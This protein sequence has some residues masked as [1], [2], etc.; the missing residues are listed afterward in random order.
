[1]LTIA[2]LTHHGMG[3]ATDGQTLVPRTLPGEVVE[4]GADGKVRII[5]PSPDRVSAPCLHYKSCGGC[6]VQHASDAFVVNWKQDIVRAA[7]RAQGL[8]ADFRPVATSPDASRRR[9]KLAGQR[10][11]KGVIVGFYARASDTIVPITDCRLLSPG[12]SQCMPALQ[13]LTQLAGSRKGKV[14]LT[15]METGVGPDVLI[16]VD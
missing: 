6:A 13:A 12:L 8:N 4:F 9:A 3:R 2:S 1:M 16:E 10:T 5:T 11:K 15:V 14:A 7:L